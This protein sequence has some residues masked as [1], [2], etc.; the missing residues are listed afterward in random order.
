MG[1]GGE[2]GRGG[3]R[4]GGGREGKG[5]GRA[6]LTQL[7]GSDPERHNQIISYNYNLQG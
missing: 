5:R 7:S 4:S 3:E 6:P 1:S 2:K